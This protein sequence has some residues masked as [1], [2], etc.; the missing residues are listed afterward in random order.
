MTANDRNIL[1]FTDTFEQEFVNQGN[2]RRGI[3]A[4]LDTGLAILQRYGLEAQ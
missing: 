3:E 2:E 4:T 1:E